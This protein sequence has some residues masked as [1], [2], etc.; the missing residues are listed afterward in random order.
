MWDQFFTSIHRRQIRLSTKYFDSTE[1]A[2]TLISNDASAL[3]E[4]ELSEHTL[5]SL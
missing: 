4:F 1:V 2:T 5:V 3:A